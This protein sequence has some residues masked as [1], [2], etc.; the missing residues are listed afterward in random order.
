MTNDKSITVRLPK[1]IVD[2]LT[3]MAS[4]K[5]MKSAAT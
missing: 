3:R 5:G 1:E 2:L 4:K